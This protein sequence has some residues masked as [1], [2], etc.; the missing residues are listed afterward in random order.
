MLRIPY[1]WL[2]SLFQK[3]ISPQLSWLL[4]I[5]GCVVFV[6][7]KWQDL[8]LPMY[9]DEI[10]VY[11]PGIL[12][13]LDHGISLLPEGL[14]PELSR[15]HPLL[16]YFLFA[17]WS[18]IVG[19][20]LLKLHFLALII[21][22]SLFV[23]VFYISKK[24]SPDL[25]A[26]LMTFYLMAQGAVF[27]QSVLALPEMLLSLEI[28]WALYFFSQKRYTGYFIWASLALLTKE[29]AL[30]LPIACA[31]WHIWL[32]IRKKEDFQL[33]TLLFACLPVAPYI[34]FLLI[35]KQT[36]GWYFFP[37]HMELVNMNS[38]EILK[39][40]G[41][42]MIWL[43]ID[44]GRFGITFLCLFS[45]GLIHYKKAPLQNPLLSLFLIFGGGF[46]AFGALNVYMDR[47][48]MTLFPILTITGAYFLGQL[49][50][51]GL[52][53][54]GV[55]V[56]LIGMSLFLSSQETFRFDVDMNY[57]D[58][59]W[60]QKEATEYL[61]KHVPAQEA[62]LANFPLFNGFQ[63]PRFGFA[64]DTLHNTAWVVHNDSM[65]YSALLVPPDFA[66]SLPKKGELKKV[67][68]KGY[69]K[70]EIYVKE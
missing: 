63:D 18:K 9:W 36:H 30:V 32:F 44:Q 12:F 28:L 22:L 61:E 40:L 47:Y 8:S 14:D 67:F 24:I 58:Y 53:Q 33:K 70:V 16:F 26:L 39:K 55:G 20:S 42:Y 31:S 4:L 25:S 69:S 50:L 66:K 3:N 21:T 5:I 68:E 59:V 10:G 19:Y 37:Y 15:G 27:A 6:G 34:G 46:L 13:M 23:S 64:K 60:V 11:G 48:L 1:L 57:R 41:D 52:V 65:N 43:F 45:L 17:S 56:A 49:K 54:V 38:T 62:F 29:S 51:K 7:L 2:V 35:Q